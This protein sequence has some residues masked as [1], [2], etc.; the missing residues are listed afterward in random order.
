M[1]QKKLGETQSIDKILPITIPNHNHFVPH[2]I[3]AL[4]N[5]NRVFEIKARE[6]CPRIL[7]V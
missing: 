1:Y 4:T 7:A 6:M 2:Y 3:K 5:T